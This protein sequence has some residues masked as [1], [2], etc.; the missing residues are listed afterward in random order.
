MQP[1]SVVYD[2]KSSSNEEDS[3]VMFREFSEAVQMRPV[4]AETVSKYIIA[5]KQ[6][7]VSGTDDPD[8]HVFIDLDMAVLGREPVAYL[9]YASQVKHKAHQ[10]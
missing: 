1:I 7:D 8:L 6:H 4:D 9:A 2:P 3:E 5:T 10:Q